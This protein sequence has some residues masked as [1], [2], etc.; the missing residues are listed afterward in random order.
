M[1]MWMKDCCKNTDLQVQRSYV[2]VQESFTIRMK[3]LK[4]ETTLSAL[5]IVMSRQTKKM[6]EV[7]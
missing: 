3:H 4:L 1:I 6:K 7:A 2:K 5:Y